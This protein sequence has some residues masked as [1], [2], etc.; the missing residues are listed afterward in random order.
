MIMKTKKKSGKKGMQVL[1]GPTM[2]TITGGD[3]IVIVDIV[4]Q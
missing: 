4:M 2:A 1:D 3:A